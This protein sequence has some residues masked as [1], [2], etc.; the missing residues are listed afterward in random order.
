MKSRE[1]PKSLCAVPWLN[2]SIDVNGMVRPCCKFEQ[3]RMESERKFGNLQV[4]DLAE[5]WNSEEM[6]RLRQDF[7]EG[8]RP[9]EC[10]SCWSE[11]ST[12]NLSL[13]QEFIRHRLVDE[14]IDF[15]NLTPPAPRVLDLKLGNLC[16]LKCRICSPVASSRFLDEYVNDGDAN[17]IRY[18]KKIK[19]Y[20]LSKKI[21]NNENSLATFK[22]WLPYLEHVE[23]F[24]GEPLINEEARE[25]ERMMVESSHAKNI[26]LLYNTNAT[27]FRPEMVELWKHFRKVSIN[28]SIDNIGIRQ[29]YERYPSKWNIIQAN[30]E[31]F[32]EI[33][34]RYEH[35]RLA[36]ACTISVYNVWYL[37][38]YIEWASK[39]PQPI[40][41]VFNF[42]HSDPEFC[43]TNLPEAAKLRI[44]AK[45]EKYLGEF[46][47]QD[48]E[49]QNLVVQNMRGV[50]GFMLGQLQ[51][52]E[53][54]EKFRARTQKFDQIRQQKY[55]EVYPEFVSEAL[56]G[57]A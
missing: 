5:I 10:A 32:L 37:P 55:V 44:A 31:K 52:P 8:R 18:Y 2:L 14:N 40:Y 50:I 48:Q 53:L 25:L 20:L 38:E 30:V 22:A 35:L 28:L 26:S 17:D 54:W 42:L 4:N 12:G 27:T 39:F 51:R 21:V 41:F 9:Q 57:Q 47:A 33:K 19:D 24:G 29:E 43:I 7:L 34:M 16:N 13:R 15:E 11:E 1:I 49:Y 23:L 6:I 3:P 46:R 36:L 45:L 56:N